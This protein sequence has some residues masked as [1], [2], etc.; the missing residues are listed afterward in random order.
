VRGAQGEVFGVIGLSEAQGDQP[1]P[2]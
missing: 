1:Q 2:N